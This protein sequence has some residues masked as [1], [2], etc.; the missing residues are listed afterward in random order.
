[1]PP[2]LHSESRP[3]SL[4]SRPSS[5]KSS[6]RSQEHHGDFVYRRGSKCHAYSKNVAPYPLSYNREAVEMNLL[7]RAL[8][9]R[10]NRSVT[11]MDYKDKPPKRVLDLGC[12]LGA[13]SID[14]AK[15]WPESEFVGFDLVDIQLNLQYVEPSIAR[16]IKWVHGNFLERLP[17]DDNSFDH[18]QLFTIA[19]G[20][21]EDKWHSLFGEIH[22]ILRPGGRVE[23]I[24][25]D[26]M[27][28]VL[29]RWF[30]QPLHNAVKR[31]SMKNRSEPST[32]MEYY[33]VPPTLPHDHA[34]LEML[35]DS[36]F[37]H[38]FINSR[39]SSILPGYFSAT[40][41][42]V[43]SPPL[44][45]FPMPPLAPLP[46]CPSQLPP[47]SSP[48]PPNLR[49]NTDFAQ[50][51][52]SY[53]PSPLSASTTLVDHNSHSPSDTAPRSAPAVPHSHTTTL[54]TLQRV[55][56][57]VTISTVASRSSDDSHSS[58]PSTGSSSSSKSI[59]RPSLAQA[60]ETVELGSESRHK[61]WAMHTL[62]EFD[63]EHTL[64]MH[65]HRA[66]SLVYSLKEAMWEEL[67]TLVRRKEGLLVEYGW[68]EHEYSD[69]FSQKRFETMWERYREDVHAR[70]ALWHPMM[71]YGWT[72]PRQDAL[73]ESELA[74]QHELRAS[75]MQARMFAKDNEIQP[76]LR[77]VRLLVGIKES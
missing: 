76:T 27:F 7:D 57:I 51:D 50:P 59:V 55:D 68:Q 64:Y 67:Q 14:A 43:I 45:Y 60:G 44:L 63:G 77:A 66:V 31:G 28:P 9:Y 25:E 61:L 32:M 4:L 62:D 26:A 48:A 58:A 71:E 17:F 42:H 70:I 5:K 74:D 52:P 8:M 30:T 41:T 10:T 13:W 2:S 37:E 34:L 3:A 19:F 38:R 53:V 20:V 39:P 54:P 18:V 1:M 40:F 29:P 47:S 12:G 56:S 65:L 73:S 21:P 36:V 46:P 24:E 6:A 75:I 16:R 72:Y 69:E 15:A 22:R 23:Q 11:F 33:S 35:F 49:V